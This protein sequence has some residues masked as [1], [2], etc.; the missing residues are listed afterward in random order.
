MSSEYDVFAD[1]NN[2]LNTNDDCDF[3][4]EELQEFN[5][6][7]SDPEDIPPPIK[8]KRGK[9]KPEGPDPIPPKRTRKKA[10]EAY[11]DL[12]DDEDDLLSAPS[13]SSSQSSLQRQSR[14]KQAVDL[15]TNDDLD[16]QFDEVQKQYDLIF[17][18]S[19]LIQEDGNYFRNLQKRFQALLKQKRS[20]RTTSKTFMGDLES[21]REIFYN[22]CVNRGLMA[23]RT[24]FSVPGPS[25]GLT[26]RRRRQ[27]EPELINLVDSPALILPGT[28]NLDSDEEELPNNKNANVSFDSENYEVSVKVKWEGKIERF[29][30]RKFQKFADMIAVLAEKSS[31]DPAHVVLNLDDRI[32][33]PDDTPD[34]IGYRISQFISGRVVR[35]KLAEMFSKK[36]TL[37]AGASKQKKPIN[38][39]VIS[40]KVQSDR[41]KKPLEVQIDK[42]QKMMIVVIKCAEELK[43]KPADIKLNF[44]GDPL[45]MDLTP[46]DLELDGGEVLDLR[47]L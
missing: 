25:S 2:Y 16:E 28:I 19:R 35:G 41:W 39:N 46:A 7:E 47:F 33:E 20:P 23:P 32:I 10:V 3:P 18:N 17:H 6:Q 5:D 36:E 44:D 26:R 13:T 37:G 1:F 11:K 30:H 29:S 43:C 45:P 4:D 15:T 8:Q 14:Q 31:S 12:S 38:A 24:V 21:L 40:L 22:I 34:S 27:Q 42:E 9:K